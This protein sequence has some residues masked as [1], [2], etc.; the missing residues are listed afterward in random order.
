[1]SVRDNWLM[2]RYRPGF[3]NSS[4]SASYTRV[5]MNRIPVPVVRRIE[6]VISEWN[7]GRIRGRQTGESVSCCTESFQVV[8]RVRSIPSLN[9]SLTMVTHP[10]TANKRTELC[11]PVTH[12]QAQCCSNASPACSTVASSNA[13]PTNINPT[14]SPSLV[15][16]GT[17][18]AGCPVTSNGEVLASMFTARSRI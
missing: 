11:N 5:T 3:A 10:I 8:R 6:V 13:S 18:S 2:T 4:P 15:P 9:G 17:E 7:A 14:G 12:P 1:M 16:A